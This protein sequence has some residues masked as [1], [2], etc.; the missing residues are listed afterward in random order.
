MALFDGLIREIAGKFGLGTQAAALVRQLIALMTSE[1]TG[2]LSGFLDMFRNAGLSD[3]VNSWIGTGE[4]KQITPAQL[5]TA[6]GKDRIDDIARKVGVAPGVA[7]SAAAFTIPK[8]ITM[9]T[10]DGRVPETLPSDVR[11]FMTAA[12]AAAAA[13]AAQP[14]RPARRVE[15][16]RRGGGFKW[17][18]IALPLAALAGLYLLMRPSDEMTPPKVATETPPPMP[19]QPV[20]KAPASLLVYN[21]GDTVK[22]DG[23]VGSDDARQSIFDALTGIFGSDRVKG[24]IYVDE[25]TEASPGWLANLKSALGAMNVPGA[26]LEL[27][28]TDVSLAGDISD[29]NRDSITAKLASIFGSGY[30]VTANTTP[31]AAAAPA[32][33]APA[34][35]TSDPYAERYS[36]ARTRATDA[37]SALGPDFTAQ[38]LVTALNY[39]IIRFETGIAELSEDSRQ[40]LASSAETI[41]RAPEGTTLEIG[42]HTDST[43]DEGNNVAL[44]Q[45]RADAVRT[46][47]IENGVDPNMLVARGYGSSQ[48]VASNDTEEGKFSNRRIAFTVQ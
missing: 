23:A 6:V 44:S 11:A 29:A 34:A 38:E 9:L 39:D 37:I 22:V 10:P 18:W 1:R 16:E 30:A 12:P 33:A 42:G 19:T 35:E 24:D 25:S 14:V 48:P 36:Q 32:P 21:K 40:F 45:A 20:A 47:L 3:V 15:E 43:G 26:S 46:T 4:S 5:E 28:G 31:P 41:T 17:W 2:G 8:V 7:G 27:R 13:T